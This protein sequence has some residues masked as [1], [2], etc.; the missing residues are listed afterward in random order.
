MNIIDSLR[1]IKHTLVIITHSIGLIDGQVIP[2]VSNLEQ[3]A[4]H[5]GV[6]IR[7]VSGI[8]P[9]IDQASEHAA[10][11]PPE[12]ACVQNRGIRWRS[13]QETWDLSGLIAF[14]IGHHVVC[15]G[16][17]DAFNG[18]WARLLEWA[19]EIARASPNTIARTRR[20]DI[21]FDRI[22][23]LK[24][25]AAEQQQEGRK[26]RRQHHRSDSRVVAVVVVVVVV[27]I[28][29]MTLN[30]RSSHMH[31]NGATTRTTTQVVPNTATHSEMERERER[32]GSW[33]RSR[34]R[35]GQ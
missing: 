4:L 5:H 34:D 11:F 7:R 6:V 32:R 1:L 33:R 12:I 18:I 10:C 2:I 23:G 13:R 26:E 15:D 31:S 3:H 24:V 17:G 16:R 35:G 27:V 29:K 25:A 14:V 8:V 22:G 28:H 19:M 20:V 9:V 30:E 21:E